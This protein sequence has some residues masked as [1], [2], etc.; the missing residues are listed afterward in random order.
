MEAAGDVSALLVPPLAEHHARVD[1]AYVGLVE[2]KLTW[3]EFN[4]A[5]EDL[6]LAGQEPI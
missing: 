3:G 1:A 4:R 5:V 6:S 2:R